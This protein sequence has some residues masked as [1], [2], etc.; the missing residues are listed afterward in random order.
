MAGAVRIDEI[1]P[2]DLEALAR[3]L[4]REAPAA[5]DAQGPGRR[6]AEH[7]RWFLF[8]NP[9]QPTGVPRGWL[10]RDAAGE[11]IGS[12]F[13]VAERFQCGGSPFT[14]LMGGGYY[15]SSAHRGLGLALMRRYLERGREHALFSS[16][17]NKTSG[18][19]YEHYGGYAI[20]N[21]DHEWLGVLNYAP[22]VEE[23]LARRFGRPN[24]ARLLA[25]A[26]SLR[27]P[28]VRA[29]A[30][31][32]GS[33]ARIGLAELVSLAIAIP[34]EHA[35]EITALR[36]PASLR[37]RY[38]DGPDTTRALFVYRSERD[39]RALV[40]VNLR[41]RGVR[42]QVRALMVLDYWGALPAA[43]IANAA[44]HLANAYRG[45]ADVVVF[46]GQPPERQAVLAKN[47]F[48]R[49]ALPRAVGVCIDKDGLLPTRSWYMVP[50]DGD[51]GH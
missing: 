40:G 4:G 44:R 25:R 5:P 16:T 22:V 45:Q 19:L 27:P 50:A 32:G 51:M 41:P 43:E 23:F 49:R 37:W 47:G 39:E 20:E 6:D 35:R 24:L 46:R 18:A 13:C 30:A 12:K 17:M 36:D 15:V 48:L 29:G 2:G 34:P 26:S 3:F 9:A 14:L 7:Y 8:G 28:S 10:A 33:L 31:R 42:G 11:V 21:T 1:G 38:F